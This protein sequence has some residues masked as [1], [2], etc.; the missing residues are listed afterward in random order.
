[1]GFNFFVIH[2]LLEDDRSKTVETGNASV[3]SKNMD[4]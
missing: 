4:S 2:G 1:M 3:T